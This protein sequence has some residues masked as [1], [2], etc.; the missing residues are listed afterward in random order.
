MKLLKIDNKPHAVINSEA[1][2]K[3]WQEQLPIWKEKGYDIKLINLI[4]CPC[5]CL[6]VTGDSRGWVEAVEK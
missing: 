1:D 6:H 5:G 4:P 3:H 2:L